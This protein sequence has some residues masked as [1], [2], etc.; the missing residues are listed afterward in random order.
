MTVSDTTNSQQSIPAKEPSRMSTHPNGTLPIERLSRIQQ[1]TLNTWRL[2]SDKLDS[3]LGHE[4]C[5]ILEYAALHAVLATLQD[6]HQ[7]IALFGR[8]AS[9]EPEFA[10]INSLLANS[11]RAD[12]AYDILDV[13]FLQ[14][15]NALVAGGAGPE[16][17]PPLHRRQDPMHSD[18]AALTGGRE[19]H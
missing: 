11:P 12:L 19:R 16:E 17:L 9:A 6:V 3:V 10:L 4:P 15:W 14:R 1:L 18:G 13:A 5:P 2:A 8:H 7:P